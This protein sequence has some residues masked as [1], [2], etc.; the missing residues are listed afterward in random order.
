MYH[1]DSTM[2]Y[3]IGVLSPYLKNILSKISAESKY[4]AQAGK[5]LDKI[6]SVLSISDKYISE[7]SLYREFV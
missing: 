1:I 5:I 2:A 6:S 4:H 3:E 7:D